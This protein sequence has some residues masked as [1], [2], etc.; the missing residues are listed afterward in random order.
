MLEWNSS[1]IVKYVGWGPTID[2]VWE[3]V[4][5]EEILRQSALQAPKIGASEVPTIKL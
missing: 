1:C 2:D 5:D 3:D 4:T